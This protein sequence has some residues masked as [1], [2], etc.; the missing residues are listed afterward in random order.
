M[1]RDQ[2]LATAQSN[3][4]GMGRIA[5]TAK[6]F[7]HVRATKVAKDDVTANAGKRSGGHGQS[8]CKENQRDLRLCHPHARLD[9]TVLRNRG[10][11][12]RQTTSWMASQATHT[13]RK[14]LAKMFLMPPGHVRCIYVEGAGCY[15]RNG[16]EDAAADAALLAKATDSPCA[17][18]GRARTSMGGIQRTADTDRSAATSTIRGPSQRG[19]RVRHPATGAEY[20]CCPTRGDTMSGL[21]S[22]EAIGPGNICRTRMFPTSSRTSKRFVTGSRRRR[23]GLPGS[24]RRR[25]QNTF[26]NE[27]FLDELAAA[28]GADP[29][30]FR[31]KYIDATTARN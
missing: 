9:R 27:C 29:I 30:E 3:M 13:L 4:V 5:R 15:G 12:G 10:I 8:G 17:C 21:S 2:G 25:T 28:V 11:Q 16:H 7:D 20:V 14:Q 26:A 19:T 23:Y 31:F 1:G 24:E 6:V 22:D 18:N